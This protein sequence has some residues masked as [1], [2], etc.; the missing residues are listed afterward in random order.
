MAKI[1]CPKCGK[2]TL[3]EGDMPKYCAHC[4]GELPEKGADNGV[5]ALLKEA[6]IEDDTAIRYQHLLKIREKYPGQYAVEFE[7]LCLGRLYERGGK[8]DFYRIPFWPLAALDTPQEYPKKKREE[9][10]RHFFENP[11]LDRVRALSVNPDDFMQEYLDRMAEGYVD[12]F[13]KSSSANSSFFGFRRREGEI[14]RRC[15]VCL[16][17]MMANVE[18]APYP[19][20][21]VRSMLVKAL[22]KAFV[23]SFHAE[24]AESCL[25][26]QAKKHVK[27]RPQ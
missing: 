9:M 12:V 17:R 24:G 18:N 13:L 19:D 5:D 16:A 27:Y 8:P 22:W 7:I 21:A 14:M 25:V 23:L 26:E 1:I 3:Y 6:L 10:L 4:A 15:A 2:A 11:E 20:E